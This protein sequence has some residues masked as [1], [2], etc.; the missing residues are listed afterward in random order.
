MSN[1]LLFNSFAHIPIGWIWVCEAS[2]IKKKKIHAFNLMGREIVVFRGENNELGALD[3]YCPHM[4][5]H[6]VDGKVE[7][8]SIRCF[9]HNWQFNQQGLCIDIPCLATM[10]AKKITTRSYFIKEQYGLI[11]LWTG[12][13]QPEF[14]IPCVPALQDQAIDYSL[15]NQWQKKCHPNVVMIN[16]ID[17]N[18]FQTVH[19]LPGHI[20]NMKPITIDHTNIHFENQGRPTANHW[21]G[22]LLQKCYRGAITYN[23]SYWYGL[24]GTVTVGPDFLQMHLMFALRPE[25][26]TTL[27]KT[28]AFTKQRR[29]LIGKL[30][31]R[32][33]LQLT[34]VVG[35][36]FAVGDTKVFQKIQ[37]AFNNPI[38]NDKAVI[39]FI[40]HLENQ[41]RVQ[42]LEPTMKSEFNYET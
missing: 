21:A 6:L 9:F 35:W 36:Y 34:K 3:A 23:M 20:L 38:K 29:G 5:A 8:N 25:K 4:G 15:G 7:G 14:S 1:T 41:S 12:E 33:L 11:W 2:K 18:H 37:F 39:A 31:N 10:P 22:R 32:C 17:E 30:L 27:G 28:I 26:G 13:T 19:K 42:W 24:V 40:K 16:A